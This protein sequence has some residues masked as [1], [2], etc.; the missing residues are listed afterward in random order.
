MQTIY[1]SFLL[2]FQGEIPAHGIL[3][4]FNI[5]Q[6]LYLIIFIV[7]NILLGAYVFYNR[8]ISDIIFVTVLGQVLMSLGVMVVTFS[9]VDGLPFHGQSYSFIFGSRNSFTELIPYLGLQI[10]FESQ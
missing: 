2:K 3:R 10:I 1:I 5:L 8:M 6:C 4:P 7:L 9:L